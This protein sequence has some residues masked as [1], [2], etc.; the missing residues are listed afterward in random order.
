MGIWARDPQTAQ[1]VKIMNTIVSIILFHTSEL[2]ILIYR[3]QNVLAGEPVILRL[4][5]II[6]SFVELAAPLNRYIILPGSAEN[7]K[8]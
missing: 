6:P 2:P 1:A 3:S 5:A 4:S 8:I 7:I